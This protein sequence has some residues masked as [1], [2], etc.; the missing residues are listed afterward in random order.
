MWSDLIIVPFMV[1]M[2]CF[3]LCFAV[4]TKRKVTKKLK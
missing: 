2:P 4:Y 1:A 3:A